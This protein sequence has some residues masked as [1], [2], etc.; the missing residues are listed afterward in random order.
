VTSYDGDFTFRFMVKAP[1]TRLY[2]YDGDADMRIDTDSA[3]TPASGFPPFQTSPWTFPEGARP[4]V[5]IDDH[6][7]PRYWMPPDVAYDLIFP[8]GGIVPNGNPSGNSEWEQFIIGLT[9]DTGVDTTV[10]SI[11]LGMYTWR[12]YGVD[13]WNTIFMH[14]EHD[15]Y[16]EKGSLGNTV[17]NDLN[18]DG[19]WDPL[20]EPG[21]NGVKV[22]LYHDAN[23]D[24]VLDPG[25][26]CWLPGHCQR[27]DERWA[28]QVHRS[29]SRL[30]SG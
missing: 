3:T 17:W 1:Q 8:G 5:S 23:G 12:W 10:G 28:V 16:P 4:G 26:R 14:V 30:V 11:P 24:K 22:N 20:T 13:A 27:F 2:L 7:N 29:G 6:P 15:L 25:S 9:G 18:L 21:I 19:I